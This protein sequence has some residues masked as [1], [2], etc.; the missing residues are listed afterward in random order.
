MTSSDNVSGIATGK[1]IRLPGDTSKDETNITL[2]ELNIMGGK[3]TVTAADGTAVD[4]DVNKNM[5]V[6]SFISKFNKENNAGLKMSLENGK[7]TVKGTAGS[8]YKLSSSSDTASKTPCRASGLL[9][10]PTLS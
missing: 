8:S 4:I 9:I 3:L 1:K 7:F 10:M 5:T 6:D 2:E